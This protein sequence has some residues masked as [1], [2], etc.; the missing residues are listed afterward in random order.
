MMKIP[1]TVLPVSRAQQEVWELKQML[2]KEINEMS[3]F[4]GLLYLLKKSYQTVERL[5]AN[6]AHRIGR[7]K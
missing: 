7:T 6:R 3:S 2:S 5:Q 1:N 4:D